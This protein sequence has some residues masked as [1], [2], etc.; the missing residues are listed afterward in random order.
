MATSSEIKLIHEEPMSSVD[1]NYEVF[2]KGCLVWIAAN[3]DRVKKSAKIS[4]AF[5]CLSIDH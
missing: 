1:A 3:R 5:F 4:L 2:A